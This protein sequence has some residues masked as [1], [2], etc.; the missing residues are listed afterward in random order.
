MGLGNEPGPAAELLSPAQSRC[1]GSAEA[2]GRSELPSP[3]ATS[4]LGPGSCNEQRRPLLPVQYWQLRNLT[5]LMFF[6][7][8]KRTALLVLNVW[9]LS[10]RC[11]S[12]VMWC[13]FVLTS[14]FLM[15]KQS[16]VS[17]SGRTPDP[18]AKGSS[19]ERHSG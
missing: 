17:P 1:Q 7:F 12:D 3:A 4:L 16:L 2:H 14:T 6:T 11:F 19:Y 8:K 18:T 13:Q 9:C 5:I 15:P 10:P